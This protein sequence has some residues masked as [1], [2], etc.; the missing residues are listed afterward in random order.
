[1]S[2]RCAIYTRK[3]TEEGLDQDFNSL[4]AQREACAAYIQSQ[5]AEGWKL[6]TTLYDDGG[7]SGGNLERPA[8]QRLLADID[9]GKIQLI[10]V[11]K[12][13]RLTRSL[14]DFAKLVER[15]DARNAS[16]VSVTQSFNTTTSMGRLTLNVLLS[17]AQFEREVTGE[18][19]RDKIAASKKKGMW[20]GGCVPLGYDC[21][22]RKL[23]V[24][25][26]EAHAVRRIFELYATLGN[27]AALRARLDV[28]G[29]RSKARQQRDGRQRGG[30][31]P[32]TG[33]LFAILRNRIYRGEIAHKAMIHGGQHEAIVP[34][35]LWDSVQAILER[36][37]QRKTVRANANSPLRGLVRTPDAGGFEPVHTTKG[38][39]RYRYYVAKPAMPGGTDA[40]KTMRLPAIE[41]ERHVAKAMT[42]LLTDEHALLQALIV[43]ED[44]A[45]SRRR[46]IDQART[47]SQVPETERWTTFRPLIDRIVVQPD[48]VDLVVNVPRLRSVLLPES[49]PADIPSTFTRTIPIV[50]HRTGHDLRLVINRGPAAR[51]AGRLDPALM[52]YIARGQE[53]YRQLTTGERTSVRAIA[54]AEGLSERHVSR[55][56]TSSLLAPEII[57]RIVQGRQP[58]SLTA[59]S[60]RERP[61]MLWAA[62]RRRW[63]LEDAAKRD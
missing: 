35:E 43:E 25:E 49:R 14:S 41:L 8:L 46:V 48:R 51:E 47:L 52:K 17:F 61:P 13:D 62:Q 26:R 36:T 30:V 63:S 7:Y 56:L 29:I 55:V 60:L 1:M 11:Y 2:L 21:V 58:V 23:V 9:A 6:V 16:F 31:L 39:R 5:R 28:D 15:L 27:V 3:S 45:E 50:L 20:M 22:D 34:G 19:I 38:G 32:S 37:R 44:P 4:D 10:V 57:E 18:R 33:A 54:Q 24:N 42:D 40:P 12:I 53:W 59:R